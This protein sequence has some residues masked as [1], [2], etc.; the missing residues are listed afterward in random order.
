MLRQYVPGSVRAAAASESRTSRGTI[1]AYSLGV[2]AVVVA[3]VVGVSVREQRVTCARF[4]GPTCLPFSIVLS[5]GVA[6]VA[7]RHGAQFRKAS[8]A[9]LCL[10]AFL[11]RPLCPV[12]S[13]DRRGQGDAGNSFFL[14]C[15]CA[16]SNPSTTLFSLSLFISLPLSLR[17]ALT[18]STVL[19]ISFRR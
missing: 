10:S 6:G 15:R 4:C 14:L 18:L 7:V 17:H 1:S 3:A 2:A 16:T 5:G 19:S 11:P 12:T 8:L 13:T 9:A